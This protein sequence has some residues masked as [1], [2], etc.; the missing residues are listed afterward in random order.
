MFLNETELIGTSEYVPLNLWMVIF[1]EAQ[2][3]GMNK[4]ILFQD[5]QSTTRMAKNDR[6]SCIGNSRYINICHLFLWIESTREK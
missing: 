3:Y 6:A 4:N 1:W 5:N 2:G